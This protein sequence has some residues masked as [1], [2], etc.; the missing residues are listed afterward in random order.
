MTAK[1]SATSVS[2][3]TMYTAASNLSSST[4]HLDWYPKRL[5]L[6]FI[7]PNGGVSIYG[8]ALGFNVGSASH[9]MLIVSDPSTDILEVL[10]PYGL[11]V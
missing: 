1:F 10:S 3:S 6:L 8:F 9:I 5:A 2:A 11:T 4:T 7:C